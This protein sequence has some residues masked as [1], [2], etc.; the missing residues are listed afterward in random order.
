MFLNGKICFWYIYIFLIDKLREGSCQ[1]DIFFYLYNKIP[2]QEHLQNWLPFRN[3]KICFTLCTYTIIVIR[4]LTF[5]VVL[6]N[7][8]IVSNIQ[9]ILYLYPSISTCSEQNIDWLNTFHLH[10]FPLEPAPYT[11]GSALSGKQ[12]TNY[13]LHS[14]TIMPLAS[15]NKP[16]I[17]LFRQVWRW[18]NWEIS[19]KIIYLFDIYQFEGAIVN[20]FS[21]RG[22]ISTIHV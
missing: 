7:L 3:I 17:M 2:K 22:A 14:N 15:Q 13:L 20:L 12:C 16:L 11:R 4:Y 8:G 9:I 6:R 10:S 21:K 19:Q 5:D 1:K 18:F